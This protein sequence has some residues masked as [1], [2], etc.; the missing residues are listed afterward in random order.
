M[1]ARSRASRATPSTALRIGSLPVFPGWRRAVAVSAFLL[2]TPGGDPHRSRRTVAQTTPHPPNL[3][4]H[5]KKEIRRQVATSLSPSQ[6]S[7]RAEAQ[8]GGFAR[9]MCE[10]RSCN[11]Q[12][13]P[14][15][16][17]L[18]VLSQCGD[19]RRVFPGGQR[20]F[21]A[22]NGGRLCP[23][24]PRHLRLV[25][26]ASCRAFNNASKELCCLLFDTLDLDA[27][28]GTSALSAS[29]VDH[30]FSRFTSFI[31]T[32]AISRSRSGVF[33]RLLDEAVQ[34]CVRTDL[35][36]TNAS[37]ASLRRVTVMARLPTKPVSTMCSA[38]ASSPRVWNAPGI[39]HS[40]SSVRQDRICSR[41][42]LL[43]P[44]M[45]LSTIFWLSCVTSTTGGCGV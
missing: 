28:A 42:L 24:S 9:T 25:R 43:K 34:R 30:A 45:Y 2:R 26:P 27:H 15:P 40:T 35:F 19:G 37:L 5:P 6:K 22:R 38:K 39:S 17:C 29:P 14:L 8:C 41:S 36:A 44:S 18:H 12:D 32:S 13:E 31:R 21:E 1:P 11:P 4:P 33:V 7:G 23:H 16:A 3:N 10:A 20:A